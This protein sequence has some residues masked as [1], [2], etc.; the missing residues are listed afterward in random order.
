MT[1][2]VTQLFDIF[3]YIWYK[4]PSSFPLNIA[5]SAEIEQ[6][7]VKAVAFLFPLD[8]KGIP[9]DLGVHRAVRNNPWGNRS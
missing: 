1:S 6:C 3:N 9:V 5:Y 2:H 4:N 8:G 7:T